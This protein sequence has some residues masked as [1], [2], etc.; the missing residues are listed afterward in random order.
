MHRVWLVT[1]LAGVAGPAAAQ[2]TLLLRTLEAHRLPVRLEAGR[3][4]GAGGDLLIR[5]GAAARFV[6]VGEEHGIA[7]IPAFT[8]AWFTAL[9]A[10]GF[11]HLAVEV[12]PMTGTLLDS[13]AAAGPEALGAFQRGHPPGFPF[14]VLTEETDLLV[15]ARRALPNAADVIWG[16]DYDILGDRYLLEQLERAAP[17]DAAR[18]TVHEVRAM[19]DSGMVRAV[20]ESNP[21]LIFLFS[22]PD[23]PF[24][25]LRTA[26]RPAPGSTADHMIG[27]MQETAAINRLFLTGQNW[28]SNH[29]RAALNKRWFMHHYRAARAAGDIAPRVMVKLG[30]NH[31]YR[32]LN[33]TRQYDVGALL[34]M[35]AESE[36]ATSFHLLVVGAPGGQRAQ[37]NPQRMEYM[38]LPTSEFPEG[39]FGSLLYDDAW[40]LFDLRPLRPILHNRRRGPEIPPGLMELAFN[41]DALLVVRDAEPS[42]PIPGVLEALHGLR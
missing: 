20:R 15:T 41:F 21:G 27:S 35:L 26:L 9:A 23:E 33:Q 11:R 40:T 5:D 42:T 16:I 38:P 30:A 29:R 36:T 34:A 22:A 1:A 37:F 2:D 18:T 39:P 28:E 3:L 6:A 25:R 32:G 14:F 19:A 31:L 12:G 24:E 13:L 8:A 17:P 10:R 7:Q 4:G